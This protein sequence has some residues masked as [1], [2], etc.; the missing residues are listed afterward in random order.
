MRTTTVLRPILHSRSLSVRSLSNN[1]VRPGPEGRQMS[2][3]LLGSAGFTSLVLWTASTASL[4]DGA[5]AQTKA[6]SGE[7]SGSRLLL[8]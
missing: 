8:L 6:T 1:A 7:V 5:R 4:G 2:L 3:R